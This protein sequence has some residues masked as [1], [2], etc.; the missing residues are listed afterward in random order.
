MPAEAFHVLVTMCSIT[1]ALVSATQRGAL[2]LTVKRKGQVCGGLWFV[3]HYH[4]LISGNVKC[5]RYR[6]MVYGHLRY[7]MAS[8]VAMYGLG[9]DLYESL[10][11]DTKSDGSEDDIIMTH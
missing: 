2:G 1:R 9:F 6:C 5:L 8:Y 3:Q 7:F 4:P 10:L 11:A